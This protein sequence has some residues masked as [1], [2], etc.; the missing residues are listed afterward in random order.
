MSDCDR[1]RE[2]LVLYCEGVLEEAP[3][4]EVRAHLAGCHACSR[5]AL[6][7]DELRRR[8]SDPEL[9]APVPSHAWQLL[10]SRMTARARAA[11]PARWRLPWNSGSLVWVSSVS[12][13][14]VLAIGSV[15]L[16]NRPAPEPAPAA[17][18]PAEAPGN[19][20]FVHRMQA[21]YA[22]EATVQY[23]TECQD[24]LLTFM[25]AEKKC[26]G[27]DYDVAF[28]VQRAQ[29]LLQ[30]KQLLDSELRSPDVAR[31]KSLCDELESFLVNLS[32]SA[33]CE[34]P[35]G[36]RRMESYIQRENL[37]LRINLLQS[38]LS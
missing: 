23:L 17:A 20:A 28:E 32:T 12:A 37:L 30:R 14:L 38:E 2:L 36:K 21:A 8:L 27:K 26:Q 16:A 25:R 10:P 1:I 19:E 35:A 6:E 7:I 31:A 13:T 11:D 3:A 18:A 22:R 9:F 29:R 33:A 5:E 34:S 24:L 4:A 15:W